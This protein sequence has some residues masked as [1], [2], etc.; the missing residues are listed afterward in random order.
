MIVIFGQRY[1]GAVDR[2]GGQCAET[3]FFHVYYL[4]VIP[5][6]S[7]WI[8]DPETRVGHEIKLHGRSVLAAYTRS[9]SLVLGLVAAIIATGISSIALGIV[10]IA[11]FGFGVAALVWQGRRSPEAE[12]RSDLNLHAFGT[13]C[14][15]RHMTRPMVDGLRGR[16]EAR[17]AAMADG[18]TP[19]DVARFGAKSAERRTRSA[20]EGGVESPEIA[21]VAY[22]LLR[23]TAATLTG[24]EAAE[25]EA[26]ASRIVNDLREPAAAD[27]PYRQTA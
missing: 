2:R 5:L 15:P 11:L 6:S 1:A 17:W 9:W 12:Q 7:I 27:G 22:G 25:A 21:V 16:L 13:R 8:L 4:P 3:Q 14:E 20:A 10:A 23:I 26:Q 19:G 24:A 18:R